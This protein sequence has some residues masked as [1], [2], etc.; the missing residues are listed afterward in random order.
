M[1]FLTAKAELQGKNMDKNMAAIHF[2][3]SRQ[4]QKSSHLATSAGHKGCC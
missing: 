4:V 1:K 3:Y 2:V